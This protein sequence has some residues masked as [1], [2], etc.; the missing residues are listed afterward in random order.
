M[1]PLTLRAMHGMRRHPSRNSGPPS[2]VLLSVLALLA[3]A[4]F[5]V[6]AQAEVQYEDEAPSVKVPPK[7]VAHH[8]EP[9]AKSS[10][11]EPGG[12]GGSGGSNGGSSTGGSSSGAGHNPSTG[13]GSGTGQG[14]SGNGP[15]GT[16]KGNPSN[17]G[18]PGSPT[19]KQEASDSSS[20][21]LVPILI[22]IAVLAA[23]SIGAVIYRQRRQ[24]GD[25]GPEVSSPEPS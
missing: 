17:S 3:L 8:S 5:P 1:F 14:V 11:A 25:D 18:Q 21:P 7:K 12:P 13:G 15:T 6:L 22:A 24:D 2:F 10:D 20:S 9:K 23:I 16:G 4:C 19:A